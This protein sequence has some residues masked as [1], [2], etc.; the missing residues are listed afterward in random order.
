MMRYTLVFLDNNATRGFF[1][2]EN[3]KD[4]SVVDVVLSC[5]VMDIWGDGRM[6]KGGQMNGRVKEEE[7]LFG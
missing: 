5:S 4:S 3:G 1:S 2:G 7:Q 6:M